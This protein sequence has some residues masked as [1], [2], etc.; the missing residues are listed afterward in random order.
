MYGHL[1]PKPLCSGHCIRGERF[2]AVHVN[3][4]DASR[5]CNGMVPGRGYMHEAHAVPSCA[6]INIWSHLLTGKWLHQ[7][8]G[9]PKDWC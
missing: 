8:L 3:T 7:Y 2:R 4:L 5:Y 9:H 6:G 1:F